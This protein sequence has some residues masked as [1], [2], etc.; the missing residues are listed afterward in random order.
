MAKIGID[1]RNIGKNRTGDE[2][3]FFGLVN[4]L[5]KIDAANKYL[6]FTDITDAATLRN[7]AASAEIEDKNN[8]EIISLKCP[9]RFIWNI[10]TLPQYLRK[11]PLD[12]YLTQ[13]ITPLFVPK[14]V[15]IA[16]IVHD[17]SF[18]VYSKFIKFS[19][20]FFLK[21]LIP[22]SFRRV[23][24]I[25]GVS[26]FTA[27]EI[28][29]YYGVSDKKVAWI[30]NA[31]SDAFLRQDISP[32]KISF[33]KNKYS[34]PDEYILYVGTLQPRKNIP[35]LLEAFAKIKYQLS[36]KLVIAGG[37]GH[38]FDRRIDETVSRLGL[39]KDV[40][41]PGFINEKD[42][43]AVMKGAQ[44]FCFPSLYEGFGIPILEAMA[45][46]TPV[47][48]SDIPPHREITGNCLVFFDPKSPQDLAKKMLGLVASPDLCAG[49][50]QKG[51]LQ[52][53]KFSW[54]K[55]AQNIVLIFNSLK[56]L[57]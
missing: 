52:V 20:L 10:W 29:K 6:L 24:K 8:F 4:G 23:D 9:N 31:V 15:K 12:I 53:Q 26:R 2:A 48:A 27:E 50:E 28:K 34:L 56:K 32:K 17:V 14:S 39:K 40:F 18:K 44:I 11:N 49:L 38:N 51:K 16:T 30:S 1:I 13:Y 46:G 57:S 42:K 22:L 19:D 25:I 54:E 21:I 7:I 45:V 43:A 5:A 41:F 36:A 3:V 55:T 33:I 47:I 35:V 37:R